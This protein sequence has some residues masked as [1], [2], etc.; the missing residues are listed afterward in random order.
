[1]IR[2]IYSP[3]TDIYF[4]LAAEEYWLKQGKENLFML[5]QDTPSVVIGRH[6]RV[7]SEVDREWAEWQGIRI[8]R[9][10]SGGGAVYH[11]LGNINLTFI[12]T[13]SRLPD[14]TVYL[15]RTLDFLSS[16]GIRAEGDERLGIYLNG[17]KIS[18]S[19]QC[20]YKDRILY[21]CTLLYDTDLA[22][23]NKVLNPPLGEE[24]LSPGYSVPSVRS[25]VTNIRP[26][27]PSR[28][29]D[30]FKKEMFLYFSQ[31]QFVSSFREKEIEAIRQL[32]EEKYRREEWIGSSS[33]R[34]LLKSQ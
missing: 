3:Y 29:V 18:G 2:C 30:D 1:M 27:L 8:A 13:V 17:R 25:E 19:A 34:L 24:A 32:R 21:H 22:V 31:S 10:F 7:Q 26:Y 12:E 4:H 28:T 23:L 9:R 16:V 6:Q 33:N 20:V 5:W 14:F 15:R 11:D